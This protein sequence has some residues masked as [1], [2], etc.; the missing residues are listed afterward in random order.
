MSAV[1]PLTLPDILE[2]MADAIPDRTAVVTS[3]RAYSYAEIDERAPRLANHLLSVGLEPG[4]QVAVHATNR[5]E[6][7]DAL[8]GCLKART[9]PVNINHAYRRDELARTYAATDCVAAIVS[10]EF[11]DDLDELD[12]KLDHRVVLG[13]DYDAKV[14]A[15]SKERP[16]VGRTP[17][18]W[19][20]IFTTGT[21]G[22]PK[23]AVWRQEDLIWAALNTVRRNAPIP[24]V[25]GLAAEAAARDSGVVLLAGGPLLHG[26]SQLLLLRALV[27]GGTAVLDTSPT[28]SAE[29]FLDLAEQAG[30][31]AITLLGDAQARPVANARLTGKKRWPLHS[32]AGVS[33]T[34]A[35]LSDGVLG[36]LRNAFA[37]RV[38]V[39]SYGTLETGVTGSRADDGSPLVPGEARFLVG[40]EVEVFNPD[41]TPAAP[42]VE[43]LLARSGPSALGYYKDN[44]RSATAIKLIDNRRWTFPGDLARREQDGSITLLGRAATLVRTGDLE[45]HPE[46]IEGVLLAHEDVVDAAVFGMPHPRWGQ[47]VAA[48][49]QLAPSTETTAADLRKHARDRLGE[50]HEPKLVLLVES[51]PRTPA[52]TVDY[53][54]ATGL[55]ADMLS[56][57]G[58][59]PD[60]TGTDADN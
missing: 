48:L 23:G 27:A 17:G 46:T 19:H 12:L 21:T 34:A 7:V 38:I 18:D 8:Y 60:E 28:F 22:T 25:E 30:A 31:T 9:I 35:P 10:P 32:L 1:I 39:D 37:R 59:N 41:L 13:P 42:G 3:D 53:R 24:S 16:T 26:Q 51:V 2:A 44:A 54:A 45:I 49:V 5:I 14:A 4:A 47:Q 40:P 29:A 11:T 50:S 36:V 55:T 6:W 58:K 43:G 57:G 56:T 20:I 52:G 33:N 15:A